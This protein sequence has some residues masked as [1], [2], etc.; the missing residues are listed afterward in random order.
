MGS[1]VAEVRLPEPGQS[2]SSSYEGEGFAIL[3][4]E[5][6]NVVK[7]ALERLAQIVKVELA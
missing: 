1:L 7:Q 2:K 6:T 4:H 3:R 5:D